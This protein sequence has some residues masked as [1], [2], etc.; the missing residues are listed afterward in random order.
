MPLR[1]VEHRA[2]R[3]KNS[4]SLTK[5]T[6]GDAN[7]FSRSGGDNPVDSQPTPPMSLSNFAST[8]LPTTSLQQN[9]AHYGLSDSACIHYIGEGTTT[10]AASSTRDLTKTKPTTVTIMVTF[11]TIYN[12]YTDIANETR[13]FN[14]TTVCC[15]QLLQPQA[16]RYWKPQQIELL[17]CGRCHRPG[18]RL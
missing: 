9:L 18:R 1:H 6:I 8:T 2:L 16:L 13:F 10:T 3:T 17:A 5:P 7:N 14:P 4:A 12:V 15:C 11:T